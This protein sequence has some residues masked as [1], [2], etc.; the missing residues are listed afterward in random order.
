MQSLFLK[1]SKPTFTCKIVS[2]NLFHR[3]Y[4]NIPYGQVIV[5]ETGEGPFVNSVKTRTLQFMVDEPSLRGG[6]DKGPAPF[7]MLLA[8]IGSSTAHTLRRYAE[9]NRWKLEKTVVKVMHQRVHSRE[10][11][12]QIY[13]KN[14]DSKVD[15]F[16]REIELIGDLT[17][18][19][20]VNLL[21]V[22][23]L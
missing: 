10:L 21:K 4:A 23:Y 22:N 16:T 20:R 11:E 14:P 1:S 7:D 19:Q 15:Q 12:S 9:E 8:A 5:E 13:T 3:R 2:K 18:E 6:S 17:H